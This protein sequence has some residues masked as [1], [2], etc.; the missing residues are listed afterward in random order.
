MTTLHHPNSHPC[1]S[2]WNFPTARTSARW[3]L[4]GL[5]VAALIIAMLSI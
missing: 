1:A 2:C 5:G 4:V 3:A